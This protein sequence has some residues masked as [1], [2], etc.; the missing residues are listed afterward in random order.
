[1]TQTTLLKGLEILE[2]LVGSRA[3]LGVSALAA[4]LSLPKSNI[5][6]TLTTLVAAGYADQ[7]EAGGY[8]PTL[9]VWELGNHVMSRHPLRRAA[10]PFMH[11]LHQETGETI[12]LVVLDGG[13]SLY[14]HQIA[15]P[16][17][18]RS[19]SAVGERAPAILT[20]S[21][22]VM[23]ALRS[24]WEACARRLH[25]AAANPGIRLPQLLKTLRTTRE[26][27]YD[28]AP[29]VWRP[30]VNSMAAAVLGPDGE[31]LAAITVAGA[32]ERFTKRRMEA[33]L[34]ALLNTCTE[35]GGALG[36]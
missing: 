18:I 33:C 17:P 2:L 6:R 7:D 9:R 1:M 22:K 4:E 3:P 27:G 12:N 10:I 21:G 24:D 23:L 36:A 8:R 35:I 19:G 30:G 31:P 5:H 16:M 28:M 25:A 26:N 34:P 20:V 15:S 13:D 29:S 32:R 11:R 14:L